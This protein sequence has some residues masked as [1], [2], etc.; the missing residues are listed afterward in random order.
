V[1][2]WSY[3][4]AAK[5]NDCATLEK[6]MVEL[7]RTNGFPSAYAP[8]LQPLLDIHLGS[9]NLAFDIL[10]YNKNTKTRIMFLGVIALLTLLIASINFINLSS[11]RA[12]KR[13]REVGLRKVVGATRTQ[14]IN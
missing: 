9:N 12:V 4:L 13:A 14:L 6:K 8:Q 3:L 5:G 10:N 2:G 7:A 1:A 11:A